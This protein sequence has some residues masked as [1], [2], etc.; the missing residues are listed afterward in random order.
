MASV[1]QIKSN[2]QLV[3]NATEVGENTAGR[4]GGVLE[5]IADH[6]PESIE[7]STGVAVNSVMSQ[8][9]VTNALATKVNSSDISQEIGESESTV[10]SQKAV[11]DAIINK[12]DLSAIDFD[13]QTIAKL[14]FATVPTRYNVISSNK[15]VG[16][17]E[18]FS[19]NM[20]HMITEVFETHYIVENGVLTGGHSDEQIFK[21]K[22]SYH[23]IEGGTSDIPVGTWGKWEQIYASDDIQNL[24][25]R[26]VNLGTADPETVPIPQTVTADTATKAL[27][28][29]DGNDLRK[30]TYMS[31]VLDYEEFST[32]KSYVVGDVVSYNNKL[33]KFIVPH[34]AGAFDEGQ[35]EETSL[36]G[37]IEEKSNKVYYHSVYQ[38]NSVQSEIKT[39]VNKAIKE[40][41]IT[42]EIA[43]VKTVSLGNVRRNYNSGTS[44]NNWDVILYDSS[45]DVTTAILVFRS[46]N[47]KEGLEFLES[48]GNY[49]LI[50]WSE[51]RDGEQIV[52]SASN[53][54]QLNINYVSEINNFPI[55]KS[56]CDISSLSV[57]ADKVYYHSL[58]INDNEMISKINKA[59]KELW[60]N[61]S[62]VDTESI[63][64]GNI[65]KNYTTSSSTYWSI[66]L[67]NSSKEDYEVVE[68]FKSVNKTNSLELIK[69]TNGS[70]ILIDWS[71]I[72]EGNMLQSKDA[73][74]NLNVPYVSDI[75]NFPIIGLSVNLPK[76]TIEEEYVAKFNTPAISWVDDDFRLTSVPNIKAICDEISCKCDFGVIPTYTEG[77][78]DYPIDSVYSFTEE[79][80][81]LIKQYELEG[82]HM[83]IHPVHKGW[84]ESAS[85]GT[86]QGR[87]W[88]EQS[89][90]KC[91]RLFNQDN[92]LNDSCIIYP[93]GSGTNNEVVGMVKNWLDMGINAGSSQYY[94]DGV[95]NRFSLNRL[96]ID[97]TRH[98]KSWYKSIIDESIEKGAWLIFGTHGHSFDDSGTVDETT[99]SLANL[100][101]IIQYANNKCPIKP[102][103]QVYRERKPM[104]D[105]YTE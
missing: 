30:A 2:A 45:K 88:V 70:Y 46:V 79:Q 40:L 60:I 14:A 8:A 75:N 7:Q 104:L 22:R 99:M 39:K 26:K 23:Y 52:A 77:S 41:Y 67:Y 55:I 73:I 20:G 27:Q 3:K 97:F 16:I 10:M 81:E 15:N 74:Y 21:Y 92:I 9:A 83:Q 33:Y 59:V 95:C 28:D 56:F 64:F 103:S 93:G 91:I 65:R 82:F 105:L 78:G 66:W 58:F 36:K 49:C 50:D 62:A 63:C 54:Y 85:A 87:A 71:E 89:L 51:V 6:L 101:E 68:S 32:E 69:G 37:E 84:Y 98:Q 61:A 57:H 94:N 72:E 76:T 29:W 12:I 100:K 11:T 1:S 44:T 53:D 86:Y 13:A 96:F 19:D 47:K 34:S 17:M 38:D 42:S 43:S 24:Y 31:G 90:V 48:N 4:V 25:E 80:L 5:D 35:V 102:I 18:V